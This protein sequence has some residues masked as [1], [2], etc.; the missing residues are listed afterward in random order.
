MPAYLPAAIALGAF[1]VVYACWRL[2]P[3]LRGWPPALGLLTAVC[4]V[5][6]PHHTLAFGVGADDALLLLGLILLAPHAWRGGRSW[7]LPHAR[8]LGWGTAIL[9]AGMSV[10]AF[11]NGEG[12]RDTVGLLVHGVARVFLYVVTVA[13][14]L[15]LRPRWRTRAVVTRGLA[16][17]G[18]AE[19]VIGLVA[20]TVGLPGGFGLEPATGNTSLLG[21][22]P[23][24]IN[25]TLELSPN[26]LGALFV[27][28]IPITLGVALDQRGRR[29]RVCWALAV[30]A[31]VVALVL[32]YTRSSLAVV[33]LACLV[34]LALRGRLRWLLAG[35]AAVAL[36]VVAT[37]AFSRILHDHTDRL[38]LYTSALRVFGDRPL[39]GVGPGRQALFT[40]ADPQRYRATSYGVAGNNAHNTVLLAAA[41][42]G[43]LG[44][45][46]AVVVNVVLVVI[47]IAVIRRARALRLRNEP[48]AAG[49]AVL[50][51]LS[52]GMANNL[53]TVT[54]TASALVLLVAGCAWPWLD[55]A[56]LDEASP[57]T[58][59]PPLPP[60][61]SPADH[62]TVPADHEATG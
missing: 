45:L 34:L 9:M 55:E 5:V 52:Q 27:L 26:F 54:L 62:G 25:G 12:V 11:V 23:G 35:L 16:T 50:A 42:N 19:A 3:S 43:V 61:N 10:S 32:T 56:H 31:Q 14:V 33:V 21:E 60:P 2:M 15:A 46:G 47:A 44:L 17:V 53:F 28:S 13:V 51:F 58:P 4:T 41:E 18:T 24:R 20:Y 40:A 49:V 1:V 7:D 36:A 48:I 6:P 29:D 22:I 38:A 37:P 57:D 59:D 30:L 39:A 8:W